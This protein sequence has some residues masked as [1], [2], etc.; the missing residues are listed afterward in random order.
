MREVSPIL[1]TIIAARAEGLGED[2]IERRVWERHG[3]TCAVLALDSSGMTR[4]SRTHG[5]VHF[6]TRYMQM[7]DLAEAILHRHGC[8]AWRCFADNLFS[9]FP[10]ADAALGAALDIH[11]ALQE[12]GL[13]VADDDPYRVCIGIGYGRVLDDGAGGKMGDEMNVVAK[14]AEDVAEAG[15]TLLSE[16]AYK[17][18]SVRAV[19]PVEKIELCLS[20]VGVTC[21]RVR[22]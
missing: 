21:Y 5:I 1:S 19:V 15:Q 12:S 16:A 7:R 20:K 3:T 8:L 22:A 13:M 14:L 10:D 17:S 2:A 11:R 9:E 4:F 6:L 18:L